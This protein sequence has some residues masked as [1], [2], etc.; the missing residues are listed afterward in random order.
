MRS[1]IRPARTTKL[2]FPKPDVDNYAKAP[3][4][5]ITKAEGYWDDDHQI[6]TLLVGKR[7]ALP[8]EQ[9]G[10]YVDIFEYK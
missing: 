7:Y 5:I 4:D 10:T 3:L 1:V 6:Q 9:E 2:L 8:D